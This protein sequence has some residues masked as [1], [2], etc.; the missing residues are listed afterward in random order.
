MLLIVPVRNYKIQSSCERRFYSV[1][2]TFAKFGQH[3]KTHYP[4]LMYFSIMI[5]RRIVYANQFPSSRFREPLYI[6]SCEHLGR[7]S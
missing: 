2:I 7:L 3:L 1:Y 5:N 4:Y 6:V